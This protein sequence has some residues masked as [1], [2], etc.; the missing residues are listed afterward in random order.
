MPLAAG[1]SEAQSDPLIAGPGGRPAGRRHAR[2]TGRNGRVDHLA[3]SGF[4]GG[5]SVIVPA[6]MS[7]GV[8]RNTCRNCPCR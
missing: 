1:L 5:S 8:L 3:L 6:G 4:G 7:L 2:C